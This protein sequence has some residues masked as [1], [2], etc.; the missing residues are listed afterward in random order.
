MKSLNF[1]E[2]W[3]KAK[4]LTAEERASFFSS[5]TKNQQTQIKQSFRQGGWKDIFLYNQIDE[6]CDLIKLYYNI[7]LYDLRIKVVIKKQKIEVNKAV[8][9]DI[10]NQFSE[11]EDCFNLDIIFGGIYSKISEK[12][13]SSYVLFFL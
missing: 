10:I 12:D 7:D 2:Y 8:W 9:D 1:Q 5:F 11:Y 6:L 3:S 13:P 4:K